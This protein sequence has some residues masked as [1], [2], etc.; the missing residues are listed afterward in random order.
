[1]WPKIAAGESGVRHLG[2][3]SL[4]VPLGARPDYTALE[5]FG[6]ID[7]CSA[8]A[9]LAAEEAIGDAGVSEEDRRKMDVVFGA[10]KGGVASFEA[11]NRRLVEK[12][13]ESLPPTF[14]SDFPPNSTCDKVA[15]SLACGGARLN[16]VSACATGT[17]SIIMAARRIANGKSDIV[18]AGS[19]E[20]SLTPLMTAAFNR[21]GV[22]SHGLDDPSA[23][24]KPYDSRRDGFAIGEGA[25]ALVVE[26]LPSAV[27]RGATIRAE[28]TGWALGTES[29]H[30][31]SMEPSGE[32]IASA[33]RRALEK[34]GLDPSDL[35]YIN[36]H[37]T[38]TR[39]NDVIE[40]RAL[41]LALGKSA[42]NVAISATKA[43]TGHLLGATGSVE[44]VITILTIQNGF[45][46][47]TI[48]LTDPD[49][50]CDL[51]YTPRVGMARDIEHALTL[52]YGFGGQIGVLVLSKMPRWETR[53]APEFSAGREKP[54]HIPRGVL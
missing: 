12:G 45:I 23:A 15:D 41:K 33:I 49:P 43:M 25:G 38:A 21:M 18:L 10:S 53:R 40:T 36:S 39:Q 9:L 5:K 1:M 48:N 6:D 2:E 20:A 13:P 7:R 35:D 46:P 50:E 52:N 17:H 24:I 14:L 34:A 11:A 28:I 3:D 37:G 16:F 29:Y 44:A 47:P 22:L 30:I 19:S 42:R 8:L 31:A 4:C 27:K 51:N 54:S 32:S 26:S